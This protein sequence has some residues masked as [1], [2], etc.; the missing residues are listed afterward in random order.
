MNRIRSFLAVI[1]AV[2]SI[3]FIFLAIRAIG[4]TLSNYHPSTAFDR[5]ASWLV[6]AALF[7]LSFAL[8]RFADRNLR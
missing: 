8:M 1:S 3:F 7:G 2:L 5:V 4:L 6:V